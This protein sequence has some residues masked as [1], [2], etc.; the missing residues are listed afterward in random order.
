MASDFVHLNV[1]SHYSL[2][3]GITSPESL[4]GAARSRGMTALALTDTNN[5]CGAIY[6]Q[7]AA[8][9]QGLRPLIGAELQTE[10]GGKERALLLVKS[11]EGY[12]ALCRIITARHLDPGFSLGKSLSEAEGLFILSDHLPLLQDLLSARGP[13]GLGVEFRPGVPRRPLLKFARETRL[14]PVATNN[15]HFLQTH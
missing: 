15:V 13:A 5:L 3:W 12:R 9:E 14:D 2:G 11:S 6:F 8:R 4:A 10:S 7:K 1:H